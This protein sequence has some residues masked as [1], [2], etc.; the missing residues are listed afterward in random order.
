MLYSA[1]CL[2]QTGER[3]NVRQHL[4]SSLRRLM[5]VDLWRLML[6]VWFADVDIRTKN[7]IIENQLMAFSISQ[8]KAI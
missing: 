8:K 7:I 4:L 2:F 1:I 5:E 3:G 6:K